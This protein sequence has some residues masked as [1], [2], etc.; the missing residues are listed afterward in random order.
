MSHDS[1]AKKFW[2]KEYKE[3]T[4]LALSTEAADDLEKF[5]RWIERRY[6]KAK[7]GQEEPPLRPG[8][9]VV[10]F[11][12]GNG[13]N[14]IYCAKEFGMKGKGFDISEEAIRQAEKAKGTLA[15]SFHVRS[16]AGS[17]PEL[18]DGS[19]DLALD[20]MTSHVLHA[21]ERDVF[22]QEILRVLK[23]GGWLFLKTFLADEDLHVKRLLK[24]HPADEEDSYIHPALGVYEHVWWE[25]KLRA[26][27][28]PEFIVRKVEKSHKH[29]LR[30][31]AWKR[32]YV[33][34][35]CERSY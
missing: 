6:A 23:P 15:I 34:M 2:N 12:C 14:L 10:D 20:M 5:G 26:F 13:R 25:A 24:D 17:Y 16:I 3:A 9:F 1:K 29:M 30:G 31:K 4:H 21:E 35:Y 27:L 11:G 33:V 18:T 22:K 8:A 7:H 32:R 28:E 19:A